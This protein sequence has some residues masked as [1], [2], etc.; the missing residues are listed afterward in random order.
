ML[1]VMTVGWW[2]KRFSGRPELRTEQTGKAIVGMKNISVIGKSK[3]PRLRRK[4][5]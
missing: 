2:V 1:S 3:E 4:S 5:G